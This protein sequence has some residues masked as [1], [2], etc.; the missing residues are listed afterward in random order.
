MKKNMLILLAILLA[1]T[2]I[3]SYDIEIGDG[4][5]TWSSIPYTGWYNYYWSTFIINS[6][7]VSSQVEV[8]QI[9]INQIKFNLFHLDETIVAPNQKIY[10]KNTSD[11]SIDGT[12]PD[13][14]NNG[15]TLVYD[16]PIT[17]DNI[18]WKGITLDTPFEYNCCDN[19]QIVYENHAGESTTNLCIFYGTH[20]E[21]D[22]AAYRRNNDS[23]PNY[24]GFITDY[25][26]HVK[27]CFDAGD[28]PTVATLVAPV[29]G[30]DNIAT[31][32][33]LEWELGEYTNSVDVYFSDSVD[34]VTTMAASA[35]V[36]DEQSVS[37]YE[38]TELENLTTY[39]W[40][41]KSRNNV[42]VVSPVWRFTTQPAD[43]IVSVPLGSGTTSAY[44]YPLN[45]YAKNSLAE[46]IYLAEE[47]NI[48]G[49]IQ[50]LTYYTSFVS[51]IPAKPVNIWV[52]E[53]NQTDL[54]TPILASDLT[55]VFSG[56]VEFPIGENLISI[57]FDTPYN[58]A[59]GNL[60]ILTQRPMDERKYSNQDKFYDT[61]TDLT[62]RT[63]YWGR[64][65]IVLDPYTM[66][67]A[68]QTV[69]HMPNV[70][71]YFIAED[72]G[73]ITGTVTDGTTG[74]ENVS[75]A[76]D[77]T[78]YQTTSDNDGNFDF[79][80]IPAGT[81][82][83]LSASL[84]GYEDTSTIFSVVEDETTELEFTMNMLETG[85][86]SGTV[87]IAGTAI[88]GATVTL[89]SN[90]VTT[91]ASG[92]FHFAEVFVGDYEITASAVGYIT[93][94]ENITVISYQTTTV[95][96]DLE[97]SNVIFG[98]NFESYPDFALEFGSWILIDG[99]LSTTYTITGTEFLNDGLPM[100]Y[101]VFN[102]SMTTPPLTGEEYNAYE[103]DKYLVSFASVP[104][105]GPTNND[106]LI[107]PAITID[108]SASVFF[109]AKSLVDQYGLER[110]NVLVS[111][112]ST[113]PEDFTCISGEYSVSAPD[114]W[115][116]Y[117]YN[118][119]AYAGQTIRVAILCVSNDAFMFMVDNFR[120]TDEDV[121]SNSNNASIVTSELLGNYPNPFNP[122]TRI[123]FF[124][125]EN[126]HVS[127]D[128]YNIKGQKVKT[129]LNDTLEAG[130]HNVTWNGTD[131]N[132]K[133]VASGVFFY[134]MKSGKYTST[135]KMILM[136]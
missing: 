72:I 35:L 26:P 108:E 93:E 104:Y 113:L 47:L 132:G 83:S 120:V 55:P 109:T 134:R 69:A 11:N 119:S 70:T 71:F 79:P 123:T 102:P 1:S 74:L 54:S 34:A 87:T 56:N 14:E 75:L 60:V 25:I 2:P 53:T 76:I 57:Q 37:S 16:G 115:T 27:L 116:N 111:T 64:D 81:D 99:D 6:D 92:N 136:K 127:L 91:D 9:D 7:L 65:T 77:G 85:S 3:F 39:Y 52:G 73:S 135:K 38:A 117:S 126:G 124:T 112:G 18:G 68:S 59:G 80:Y 110:F 15:Y 33:T 130:N 105:T 122:E 114:T 24:S 48:G 31:T 50:G 41:V 125:K 61:L 78:N 51:D 20:V 106:W 96:F 129:L 107:T 128:I 86:V 44:N 43:G 131:D 58:Y 62:A 46:T 45:F 30:A 17:W 66:T 67:I 82:Y 19:L 28:E 40:R 5:I 10:F 22:L 4:S 29:S 121:T 49:Q 103:G 63:R 97:E 8:N 23:F 84:Y 118:L 95:N 32:T 21:S 133:N 36:V 100:A 89:D 42:A 94:S 12:Y 88:N 13:P 90:T 101:I 98:D